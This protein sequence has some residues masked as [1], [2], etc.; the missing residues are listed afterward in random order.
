M[1]KESKKNASGALVGV[2][3]VLRR[4][5]DCHM[6]KLQQ[7]CRLVREGGWKMNGMMN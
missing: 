7:C 2:K 4:E 3:L 5:K 1:D 6:E